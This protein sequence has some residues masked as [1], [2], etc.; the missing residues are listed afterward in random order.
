ML[1]DLDVKEPVLL[2][3]LDWHP[4]EAYAFSHRPWS[5]QVENLLG[6]AGELRPAT[7]CIIEAAGSGP[8]PLAVVAAD[9]SWWA[10]DKAEMTTLAKHFKV[11]VPI[12]ASFLDVL[13]LMNMKIKNVS[14]LEAIL[15]IGGEFQHLDNNQFLE[16]IMEVDEAAKSLTSQDEDGLKRERE[17]SILHKETF[18]RFAT[19]YAQRKREVVAKVVASAAALAAPAAKA[20]GK[21]KAK[22][23]A[24]A[25]PPARRP[26]PDNVDVLPQADAKLLL[27]TGAFIWQNR[28]DGAWSARLPPFKQVSRSWR[29]HTSN[30][31][32][33]IVI[34]LVWRQKCAVDGI[35]F[36][37]CPISGL[38]LFLDM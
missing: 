10:F 29:K 31:A 19:E 32:M 17:S 14:E 20:A 36:S 34:A 27:P 26:I 2:V 11:D 33:K 5:W 4:L 16:E 38:E 6:V 3:A 22:A 9:A 35:Q 8:Q 21:A 12:G 24:F 13:T 7:R 1:P 30:I 23:K 15:M 25:L 37:D 28:T 18:D